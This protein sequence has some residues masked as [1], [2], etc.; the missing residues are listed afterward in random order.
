[1]IRISSRKKYV[2]VVRLIAAG[3]TYKH[4]SQVVGLSIS[5]IS[6]VR[7]S[8]IQDESFFNYLKENG[9]DITWLRR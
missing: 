5:A 1:M 3:H 7:N 8:V 6:H 9:I 4:I 2:Q